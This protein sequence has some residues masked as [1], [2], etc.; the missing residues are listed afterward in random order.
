MTHSINASQRV[1]VTCGP[2]THTHT[3][4]HTHTNKQ[5]YNGVRVLSGMTEHSHGLQT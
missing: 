5:V 3:H 1:A 4:T 2:V